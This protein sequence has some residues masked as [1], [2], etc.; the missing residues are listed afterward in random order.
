MTPYHS[1][2][3]KMTSISQLRCHAT[4]HK[5]SQ[6]DAS[7]IM[8]RTS[9]PMIGRE[10]S[11]S[12]DAQ[13]NARKMQSRTSHRQ[14]KSSRQR[15]FWKQW[16]NSDV[17]EE[18]ERNDD[19]MVA[20]SLEQDDPSDSLESLDPSSDTMETASLERLLLGPFVVV[21]V[22]ESGSASFKEEEEFEVVV[23]AKKAIVSKLCSLPKKK[24]SSKCS[25]SSNE[26]SSSSRPN[27]R[28][29][30]KGT[31]F[32]RQEGK[33]SFSSKDGLADTLS[34]ANWT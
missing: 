23:L 31:T 8:L 27:L 11:H 7:P 22:G 1:H 28:G 32:P 20:M 10:T 13:K 15:F 2:D 12:V 29:S 26:E 19:S 33:S 5:K 18:L 30:L 3:T 25:S 14:F 4:M 24:A 6:S 17:P 16:N 21:T 34:G 9:R